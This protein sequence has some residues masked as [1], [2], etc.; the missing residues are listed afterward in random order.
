MHDSLV[1]FDASTHQPIPP[2]YEEVL[3][4]AVDHPDSRVADYMD[5]R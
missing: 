2:T 5:N 4:Y 3:S 1:H